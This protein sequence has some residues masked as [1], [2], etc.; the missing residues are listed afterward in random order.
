MSQEFVNNKVKRVKRTSIELEEEKAWVDFYR[1]VRQDPLLA[2]EVL[3]QLESDPIMRR[4]HMALV[5]CCKESLRTHKARQTRNKRIGQFV[6]WL[7]RGLI[8]R[9]VPATVNALRSGR[10]LAV[11]CLPV[12]RQEPSARQVRQLQ[13]MEPDL[14]VAAVNFEQ[15]SAPA[16][17]HAASTSAIPSGSSPMSSSAA[18]SVAAAK[19]DNKASPSSVQ[20]VKTVK[21]KSSQA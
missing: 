15:R 18:T 16:A 12:L 21:N 13:Q 5:L 8:L 7:C 4:Q 2:T 19:G 14:G 1:R 9:P 6:R 3:N 11:E 20:P 10:D 17:A